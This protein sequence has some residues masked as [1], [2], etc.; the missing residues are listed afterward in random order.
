MKNT[1][2]MLHFW[3]FVSVIDI[4]GYGRGAIAQEDLKVGDIALEIPVSAI[5][6]EEAMRE[7]DLVYF[8]PLNIVIFSYFLISHQVI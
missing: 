3:S 4:E 1:D 8:R 2:F 7:S 6:S 5:I